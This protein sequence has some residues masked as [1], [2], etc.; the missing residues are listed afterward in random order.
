MLRSLADGALFGEAWGD[1]PARVVALHGWRRT[2][3]DFAGVLGPTAPGG[4]LAAVAPDLPGFGA[5]PPPPEAWG[6]ADYARLVA[7]LVD[8]EAAGNPVVVLGHSFGGRVGVMLA[9]ERPDLVAGLVLTGA[10]V[11]PRPG[12]RR[13]PPARYRL[14]RTLRHLGLASEARLERARQ[15]YGSADY[16]ASDGVVRQVLVRLLTEDYEPALRSL[17]C[18]VEMV[19][20]DDDVEAPPAVAEAVRRIVPSATLTLCPGAGHLTPLRAP[21]ELRAAVDRLLAGAPG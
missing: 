21:G 20:G 13:R 17:R 12:P 3:A 5:T 11:A 7:R 4:A 15:R 14:V 2:H 8:T 10:P 18:P 16:R 6:S 9:A 1:G 19:W